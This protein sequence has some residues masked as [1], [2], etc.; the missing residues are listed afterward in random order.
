MEK[1]LL[2]T[3][4]SP[5]GNI[6]E[7]KIRNILSMSSSPCGDIKRLSEANL[8]YIMCNAENNGIIIISAN[9]D[10]VYSY[11]SNCDLSRDYTQCL[12]TNG[13]DYDDE[14]LV[15]II[16][17]KYLA[18]HNKQAYKQ[19]YNK[20]KNTPYSYSQLYGG[21]KKFDGIDISFFY[22]PSFLIY[23]VDRSGHGPNYMGNQLSFDELFEFGKELCKEYHQ[24]FFYAQASN[25]APNYYDCDGNIVN[26]ASSQ[27]VKFGEKHIGASDIVFE[28]TDEGKHKRFVFEHYAREFGIQYIERIRR[29]QIGERLLT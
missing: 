29:T 18:E 24:E 10:S 13:Y 6:I 27:L 9:R 25:E 15:R 3:N 5:K 26:K 23:C 8:N 1:Q 11:D 22:E 7:E 19:L 12:L 4:E 17:T 2:K 14:K 16:A 21:F 20:I 28:N